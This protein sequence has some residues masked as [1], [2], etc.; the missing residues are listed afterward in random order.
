MD[1]TRYT[2]QLERTV[3]MIEQSVDRNPSLD[4]LS[5][6]AGL[7]KYHLHHVFRALTGFPLAEYVRRRRLSESLAPLLGTGRPVIDIALDFGFGYEQSYIR[8][9]KQ[10]YGVSPGQCRSQHLLLPVTEKIDVHALTAIGRD[11]ALLAPRL[12]VKP[13]A[14][15][16]GRR[17]LIDRETNRRQ[18]LVTAFAAEFIRDDLHRIREPKYDQRYVGV[19]WGGGDLQAYPY[20][21]GVELK[22]QPRHPVPDGLELFPIKSRRYREFI[23]VARTSPAFYRYDDFRL[24]FE[25]IRG[26]W[27]PANEGVYT[28][29]WEMEY[30]DYALVRKDYSE[31][32]VLIP[33]G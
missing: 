32:R 28:E 12:V 23:Q 21:T 1:Y 5:H 30:I 2:D 15:I 11:S 29:E 24:L 22:R 27:L 4:E 20:I 14:L 25:T 10:C 19:S 33:V 9:F 18:N 26:K 31:Y 7:S 16:C 17:H 13:P 8:A 3:A 6:G